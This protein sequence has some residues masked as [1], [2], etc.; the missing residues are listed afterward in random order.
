MTKYGHFVLLPKVVMLPV[1]Y[2]EY[3]SELCGTVFL[4]CLN[5]NKV[6]NI[7]NIWLKMMMAVV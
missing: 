3:D 2:S 4:Y 6:L 5:L 1:F 7:L